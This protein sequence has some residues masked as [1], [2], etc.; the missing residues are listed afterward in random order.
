[1]YFNTVSALKC[2]TPPCLILHFLTT[3][4]SVLVLVTVVIVGGDLIRTVQRGQFAL[5]PQFKGS[6]NLQ[7]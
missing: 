7:N 1:M 4:V 6:P 2:Y 5:G 3:S